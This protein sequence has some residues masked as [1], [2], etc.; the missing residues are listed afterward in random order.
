MQYKVTREKDYEFY[1][2]I[3]ADSRKIGILFIGR[4]VCFKQI[5]ESVLITDNL[6][7]ISSLTFLFP[8]EI[9]STT[10]TPVKNRKEYIEKI[11]QEIINKPSNVKYSYE[12]IE[13]YIWDR[14]LPAKAKEISEPP[15]EPYFIDQELS[16]INKN[17]PSLEFVDAVIKNKLQDKKPIYLIFG[18]GGAGKTTFCEQAIQKI[19]EYQRNGHKKKAILLSSYDIPEHQSTTGV[20]IESL[21]SLYSIFSENDENSIDVQSLTLNVSSGNLLII[22]D[23]LDEIQSKLKERFVLEKFIESVIKLNDTYLNC[24]VIITSREIN[25]SVFDQYDVDIFHL[26]GFDDILIKKYLNKRFD[27]DE[28]T[29]FRAKENITEIGKNS[30]ITPLIIR[31]ICDLANDDPSKQFNDVTEK[32]FKQDNPLDKVIFQLINREI[33]KQSLGIN[34]DE[35]FEILRDIVFEYSGVVTKENFDFIIECLL[36]ASV[37]STKQ[38]SFNNFYLS[39]LLSNE[40]E[41]FKIKYDSLEFWIKARNLS[42]LINEKDDELNKNVLKTLAQDCYKGGVLV[43]EIGKYKKSNT[44]YECNLI[45]NVVSKNENLD[46]SQ[47]KLISALL[48]IYFEKIHSDKNDNSVAILD[49]FSIE[50]N[51]KIKGLSIYG[52]FYPL[53]FSFFTV[54][55]GYFNDYSNLA[56]SSIPGE[57]KVFYS[58]QFS[59][60]SKNEFGKESLQ[61]ENFHDDCTLCEEMLSAIALN[62][63]SNENKLDHIK[64]DLEK[65][66]KVGFKGSAFIWKSEQLY[67]SKC[68][69]LKSNIPLENYLQVLKKEG[70][71]IQE[72][73][74]SSPDIGYKV[75]DQ[76]MLEI[77]EFLSQR[78]ISNSINALMKTIL[79]K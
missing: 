48:Y 30:N 61:K 52:D 16:S 31:L 79:S 14:C 7:D 57:K 17:L 21:Q 43:K 62:T 71:L 18:D 63:E 59:N 37:R 39:I 3:D 13:D 4:N 72:S 58:S 70:F 2:L 64:N 6:K 24:S 65:I 20:N 56:K 45:R 68:T 22:I 67:L 41:I 74:K 69:S 76:Y 23:G 77:K 49:V 51:G 75:S 28:K 29:I 55:D 78:L 32:Y 11:S 9:S 27:G 47:R 26:K 12:F 8:I 34:C 19:N 73:A 54:V 35:Y 40:N 36:S 38:D 46:N 60:I 44:T 53:D 66:F 25:K 50:K 1:G 33:A 10:G 42:Y 15:S 5:F